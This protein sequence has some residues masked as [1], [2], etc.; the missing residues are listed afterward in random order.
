M[1]TSTTIRALALAAVIAPGVLAAQGET[2][3]APMLAK[4]RDE[5]L[6]RSQ[7]MDHMVWLTDVYGP[8]LTGSPTF[9]QAGDWAV[10]T[11]ASWGLA[12]PHFERWK[13]GKGWSLVHFDAQM[14]EPQVQPL[15]GLPKRGR[16]ERTAL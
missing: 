5:G 10:K 1:K 6:N 4:I 16:R 8:R 2:I 9:Q 12:N 7:V 13:F 15:I 3:D 14:V 11:L